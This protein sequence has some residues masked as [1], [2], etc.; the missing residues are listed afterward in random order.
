MKRLLVP[1]VAIAMLEMLW[2]ARTFGQAAKAATGGS[3]QNWSAKF[4]QIDD[5]GMLR[6]LRAHQKEGWDSLLRQGEALGIS[7]ATQVT[8]GEQQVERL[9][10][11]AEHDQEVLN[12]IERRPFPKA[13]AKDCVGVET[14]GVGWMNTA[15][16]LH[17][18]QNEILAVE[19]MLDL[20]RCRVGSPGVPALPA[21]TRVITSFQVQVTT[22]K[23]NTATAKGGAGLPGVEPM[24]G[25][26]IIDVGPDQAAKTVALAVGE[27]MLLRFPKATGISVEPAAGVLS[28]PKG[29][30]NLPNNATGLARAVG[31]GSA[32]VNV[33]GAVARQ[34]SRNP[35]G[36]NPADSVSLNWSGYVDPGTNL[37][38]VSGHWQVPQLSGFGNRA[39]ASWIGID[40]QSSATLLQAG[41]VQESNA[42]FL[43]LGESQDYWAF[44]EVVPQLAAQHIPYNV[45]PGDNI[46]AVLRSLS[47]GQT[48]A[49]SSNVWEIIV[50]DATQQWTFEQ[51]VEYQGALAEA[52]WIEEAPTSC[53]LVICNEETLANYQNITFAQGTMIPG[54]SAPQPSFNPQPPSPLDVFPPPAFKTGFPALMASESSSMT[55]N[56]MIVSTP[57]NPDGD[58]DG[59]TLTF[60]SSVPPAPG[61]FVTTTTLPGAELQT[62]YSHTLTA[63]GA[64][65]PAWFS[66]QLPQGLSLNSATGVISGTPAAQG[67]F[68]VGVWVADTSN[69]GEFSQLQHLDLLVSPSYLFLH[70]KFFPGLQKTI[71]W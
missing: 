52:D 67:D 12:H 32:K 38:F 62:P 25:G 65:T 13:T 26:R 56:S 20:L 29:V 59:F 30:Y 33:L 34:A 28:L 36:G 55:Q 45:N 60:G 69:P 44:W 9:R 57:S 53:F 31:V 58:G 7:G 48:V 5:E 43:G 37:F 2:N 24:P 22:A 66:S 21:G 16:D 35:A 71:C 8:D 18:R 51:L 4:D 47:Q 63:S 50:S 1:V 68:G 10:T 39:S 42:G 54:T 6:T 15:C 17:K 3:C 27:T 61:P 49:G 64:A 23:S 14:R 19:G 40:G 70:C 11:A 46:T 41:T